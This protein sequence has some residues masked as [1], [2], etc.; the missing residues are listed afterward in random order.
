VLERE[1]IV[2]LTVTYPFGCVYV[3]TIS[4]VVEKGYL[5]VIPS[6]FTPNSDGVNDTFRPVSK[7]L[8]NIK[9]DIYDSWGSV[10]YSETGQS[11]FGWNGKINDVNAENGNYYSTIT[12]ETFYGITIQDKQTF[13][14]IK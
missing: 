11:L 4:L 1:Y 7:R 13:V 14:L 9:M 12:A 8:K 2:T 6:A 3:L 10:I 5:L